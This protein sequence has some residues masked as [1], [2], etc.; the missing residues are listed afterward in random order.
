MRVWSYKLNPDATAMDG[1]VVSYHGFFWIHKISVHE[2]VQN[3]SVR[4]DLQE[5]AAI[6]ACAGYVIYDNAYLI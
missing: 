3:K 2:I 6:H 1:F 4:T 5:T